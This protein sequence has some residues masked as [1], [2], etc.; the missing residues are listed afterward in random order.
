VRKALHP[1]FLYSSAIIVESIPTN[2]EIPDEFIYRGA[3]W[4][5]G[6]GMCQIGA[7]GMS[8]KGYSSEEIMYH[9]YPG[10]VLKKIY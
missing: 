3:G 4:G 1:S 7:L 5:H 6:V 8:L 10:S 9:Y 2:A